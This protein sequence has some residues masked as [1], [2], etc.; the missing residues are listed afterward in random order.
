MECR[1]IHVDKRSFVPEQSSLVNSSVCP[2]AGYTMQVCKARQPR[3]RNV[4]SYDDQNEKIET[5][6]VVQCT[7]ESQYEKH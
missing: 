2:M 4:V 6:R 5:T 3:H 7:Q 1:Q